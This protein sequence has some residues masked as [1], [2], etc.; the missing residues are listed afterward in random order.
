MAAISKETENVEMTEGQFSKEHFTPI[1][2]SDEE[3]YDDYTERD[4]E[5]FP[6]L[7]FTDEQLKEAVSKSSKPDYE[8]Y[9][10]LRD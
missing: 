9:V 4:V 1:L 2:H 7:D 10:Q 8:Q 5:E 6:E 3:E